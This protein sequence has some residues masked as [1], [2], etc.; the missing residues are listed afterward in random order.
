MVA[1]L[2]WSAALADETRARA[3]LERARSLQER[4]GTDLGRWLREL[5]F[6]RRAL[7]DV[8][9]EPRA[10]VQGEIEATLS[11]GMDRHLDKARELLRSPGGSRRAEL[12]YLQ[13][14]ERALKD[15]ADE[16]T[17]ARYGLVLAELRRVGQEA[18]Q[19]AAA[20]RERARAAAAATRERERAAA[21]EERER[22]A[23]ER[24]RAAAARKS[25]ARPTPSLATK[26]GTPAPPGPLPGATPSETL[27]PDDVFVPLSEGEIA[28]AIL[29]FLVLVTLV[30]LGGGWLGGLALKRAEGRDPLELAPIAFGGFGALIV[31]VGV[32]VALSED[33]L[34]GALAAAFGALFVGVGVLARKLLRSM[35]N[36]REVVVSR[37]TA[38]VTTY[39]GRA[40]QRVQEVRLLVDADASE[41][42]VAAAQGQW[43]RSLWEQRQDWQTGSL[44][45]DAAQHGALV[46]W[47]G[48]LWSLLTLALLGAAWFSEEGVIAFSAAGTGLTALAFLAMGARLELHRRKFGASRLELL[49]TPAFLGE[50]LRG[51]LHTG[52]P[53][54]LAP[55]EGFRLSLRC[56]LSYEESR[57]DEA[58]VS[59]RAVRWSHEVKVRGLD[60]AE[61]PGRLDVEVDLELPSD[62]DETSTLGRD[63][64]LWELEVH[65]D[66]PG[67]DYRT[68]FEIPVFRRD[69]QPWRG[70]P[71]RLGA[72]PPTGH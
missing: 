72:L 28:L 10:T 20:E 70:A 3:H 64:I 60:S 51:V 23:A 36:A 11:A 45:E 29:V 2:G 47:G 44:E 48:A 59:R 39:E 68:T 35:A 49:E 17:Q 46:L 62:Q 43:R 50:R 32:G 33:A 26:R 24:A 61:N 4:G 30:I 52:V 13:P 14:A 16:A 58:D 9:A 66:L 53:Q 25:A 31:V 54:Q 6:A 38:E 65:A 40:A 27:S 56:V 21:A 71:S 63:G 8:P 42:E 67:L 69:E 18:E 12:Y 19:S 37:V 1:L 34:G 5:D 55:A 7:A 57:Q 22:V 41:E 15:F